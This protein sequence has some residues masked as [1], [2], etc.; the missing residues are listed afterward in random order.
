MIQDE[1]SGIS[2]IEYRSPSAEIKSEQSEIFSSFLS[3]IDKISHEINMG[4]VDQIST[5]GPE[6]HHCLTSGVGPI[7]V[8][9]I[10]EKI[11]NIDFWKSKAQQIGQ[12]FLNEFG[13]SYNPNL[14]SR[15]QSFIPV[16]KKIVEF[17]PLSATF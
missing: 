13:E 17:S 12:E 1:K 8:I 4:C 6:G 9:V 11:S 5:K 2:L 15:F 10:V 3:A 7:N 16:L 14:T